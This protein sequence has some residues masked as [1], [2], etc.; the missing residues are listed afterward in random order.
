MTS[1]QT[2][3]LRAAINAVV[4][5]LVFFNWGRMTFFPPVGALNTTG[6]ANLK[7]YT[8]LSNLLEGAA[9]AVWLLALRF[10][11]LR[12]AAA[13][14]KFTGGVGVT[15]TFTVVM[16]FLGPLFGYPFMFM[17]ANLYYHLIV[18]LLA[19]AELILLDRQRHRPR[20]I[21]WGTL[22]V[23]AYG[24]VYLLNILFNGVGQW[25]DT[26]D[27]YGFVTGGIPVGVGIFAVLCGAAALIGLALRQANLA[28][29]RRVLKGEAA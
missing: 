15:V 13:A 18:P 24:S 4:A 27:W 2:L 29:T 10:P 11:R 19:I 17:G 22:T 3:A 26:N 9:C 14:L 7:F 12:R 1:K 25:P 6:L 5:F 28:V 21:L 8:V 20:H 16:A 23:V